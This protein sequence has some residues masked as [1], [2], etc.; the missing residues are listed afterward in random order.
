M[1]ESV[2]LKKLSN[3]D[4]VVLVNTYSYITYLL[5]YTY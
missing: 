1:H 3:T 5:K 4:V 2:L